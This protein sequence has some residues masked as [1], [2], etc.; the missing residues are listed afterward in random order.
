MACPLEA[1]HIRA[2]EPGHEVRRRLGLVPPGGEMAARRA[3]PIARACGLQ[4]YPGIS[5]SAEIDVRLCRRQHC[6]R[7]EMP[8]VR[9]CL[10]SRNGRAPRASQPRCWLIT[11]RR[12]ERAPAM[13]VGYAAPQHYRRAAPAQLH[14][15]RS[16]L[17]CGRSSE[18][19]Q[20][21]QLPFVHAPWFRGQPPFIINI[22]IK[23]M[24]C[25]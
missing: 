6:H 3:R 18:R 9:L 5:R 10:P 2:G 22:L 1:A 24:I 12:R 7:L 23:L 13:A 14:E 19:G 8:V 25:W 11:S 4:E 16:A 17:K 20:T 15:R 21:F